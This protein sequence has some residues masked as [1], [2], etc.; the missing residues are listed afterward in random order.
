MRFKRKLPPEEYDQAL[1]W[2]KTVPG[3]RELIRERISDEQKRRRKIEQRFAT[4]ER[5]LWKRYHPH[6]PYPGNRLGQ[7]SAGDVDKLGREV[8]GC[9]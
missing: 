7:L 4:R 9:G 1:L 2:L 8:E 5:A 6:E 3:Y